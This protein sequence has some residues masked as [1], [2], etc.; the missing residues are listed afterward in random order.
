MCF[1]VPPE[2]RRPYKE[3]GA[4]QRVRQSRRGNSSWTIL[5]THVCGLKFTS[6]NPK[7]IF[8][9]VFLVSTIGSIR[10]SVEK[11]SR[12]RIH[13]IYCQREEDYRMNLVFNSSMFFRLLYNILRSKPCCFRNEL[14]QQR[15]LLTVVVEWSRRALP[16]TSRLLVLQYGCWVLLPFIVTAVHIIVCGSN[17]VFPSFYCNVLSP[18][19]K[20]KNRG[21]NKGLR[22]ATSKKT[23]FGHTYTN[24]SMQFTSSRSK[25]FFSVVTSCWGI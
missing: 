7:T 14:V 9:G 3:L 13:N 23:K 17:S 4:C 18:I 20:E 2:K 16:A 24:I 25:W 6:V 5:P 12:T 22:T 11:H 1:S 21:I 15:S 19:P 8:C 10:R